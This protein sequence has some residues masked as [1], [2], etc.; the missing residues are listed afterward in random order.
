MKAL[1]HL[2]A[3]IL[4]VVVC[5]GTNA[6]SPPGKSDTP[7]TEWLGYNGGY[8]ATRFSPLTQI[9]TK[10][11]AQLKE[12]ARFKIPETLSFQSGPVVVGD[13][14]YVTTRENTY[15]INAR[16]GAQRW[17]RHHSSNGANL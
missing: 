16:T 12:V 7:D 10:N 4:S 3:A 5:A 2:F 1:L 6:Q 14:M 13:T 8:D 9:N 17:L 15:A 11:V